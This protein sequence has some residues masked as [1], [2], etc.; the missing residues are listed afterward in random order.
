MRFRVAIIALLGGLG[1]VLAAPDEAALRELVGKLDDDAFVVRQG[2][3]TKL[4]EVGEAAIPW[5]RTALE[6]G[7]VEQRARAREILQTI[8]HQRL[9]KGFSELKL[10]TANNQIVERGMVL[11]AQILDP[12]VTGK[13]IDA[14]LDEVA[15][16]VRQSLAENVELESLEGAEVVAAISGVLKDQY[17]LQGDFENY[18]HPDNSSIHRTFEQ[19]NGLPIVLS[20]IAVAVGRR[21]E[22]PIVG[23]PVPGN[24]MF[25]Y[26][27]SRAPEG[28]PG[29][30]IIVDAHGGWRVQQQADV[31]ARWRFGAVELEPADPTATVVRM[32]NNL[33]SDFLVIGDRRR[34]SDVARYRKLF[35]GPEPVV[36]EEL[37]IPE[38][39]DDPFKDL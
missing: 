20:E 31:R 35:V 19:G 14:K 37:Q 36:P 21:L 30:D 13:A 17:E 6:K 23:L 29:S 32:L 10:T 24:Y 11:I 33:E 39:T 12:E 16:A 38:A 27:G 34:A 28:K 22:V 1:S 25:K 7:S 15:D 9:A 4:I 2:A 8:Q 5:L 26:E 18:D 3:T